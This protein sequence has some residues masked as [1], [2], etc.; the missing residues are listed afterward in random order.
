LSFLEDSKKLAFKKI[1]SSASIIND[2]YELDDF[3]NGAEFKKP[4]ANIEQYEL[5]KV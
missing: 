3:S 1:E 2:P 4:Y 5:K